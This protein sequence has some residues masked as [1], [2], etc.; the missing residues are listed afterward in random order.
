MPRTA[1]GAHSAG[2]LD[3]VS[4]DAP[5]R[6]AR[7]ADPGGS[8]PRD[9]PAG[10]STAPATA[11]HGLL[12]A[13]AAFGCLVVALQQTL[14]VPAVPQFPALLGTT[15]EAVGWLVTATL[16]T[17]A[18]ATPIIGRLADLFGKR[19]MLVLSMAFV[20]LG[21]VIAPLGG[22]GT[23][24][25]GRALQGLG[26]ALVPVAMAQMRD[27]LP[28]HRVG[29]ALAILSATLGVGGGIGVPLG[30]VILSTIGWTG[31]F[32]T[33]AVLS[34]AAI[35]LIALVFPASAPA[36]P[37][38][39]FDLVGAVLLSIALTSLLLAVSQ[40]NTWGWG[41]LASLGSL[42]VGVVS[43]VA[44]GAFELRQ[45]SPLV[46]LRTSGS[47]PLLFTNAASILMGILMFMNLLLTTRTLQ[48]PT[49]EG[50]FGW[51]ASAAGLAMLPNAA[52]MFAVAALTA[53][54]AARFGPRPVLEIGGVV[55]A[56]GYLLR[57]L[58][59][60]SAPVTIVWTTLIGIGV[61]IAYAA[62]PMLV[63]R[64]APPRET[65]SANGVNALMRAIGSAIAS[66]LVAAITAGL[67][68]EVD[69]GIVPSA[70][71]LGTI[72]LI[73]LVLSAVSTVLAS[74]ARRP[75]ERHDGTVPSAER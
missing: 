41:S 1:T 6:R 25:L 42:L 58:V 51:S 64:Y 44:W 37:R 33:S 20:L 75:G 3:P 72:A 60:P 54:L 8:G 10:P 50:G 49:T 27:S 35:L 34:V 62:M 21:S 22:I 26:T 29:G 14:V 23:L 56:L 52:A 15:Q 19:R 12:I 71:S 46:D 24:V 74:F 18:V 30:G 45:T 68:A 55:T 69:G 40:G 38:G 31:M 16:L 53:R 13:V 5:D 61:G 43:A 70:A 9:D 73:G 4:A 67:V 11:P 59:T 47:R 28:P 17:G 7:S 66:A 36:D 48:N 63:V 39:R 32:W 2:A 65:G 57:L